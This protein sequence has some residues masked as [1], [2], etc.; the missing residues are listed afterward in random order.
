MQLF[1]VLRYVQWER[2]KCISAKE[3]VAFARENEAF[4]RLAAA[5]I[6]TALTD[7]REGKQPQAGEARA[8]LEAEYAQQ[9]ARIL[10]I[11]QWPPSESHIQLADKRALRAGIGW[12]PQ[13]RWSDNEFYGLSITNSRERERGQSLRPRCRA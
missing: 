8:W 3:I 2:R 4:R 13:Q 12:Y 7:A 5:V 10:G 6:L 9:L 1:Q 11:T